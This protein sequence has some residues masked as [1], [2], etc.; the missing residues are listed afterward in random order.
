MISL[1][2]VR[3]IWV[4]LC[5]TAIAPAQVLADGAAL[6]AKNVKEA[7]EGGSSGLLGPIVVT[8]FVPTHEGQGMLVNV[9]DAYGQVISSSNGSMCVVPADPRWTEVVR[10]IA[11]RLGSPVSLSVHRVPLEWSQ[12]DAVTVTVTDSDGG[13]RAELSVPACVY[14]VDELEAAPREV[15]L[16]GT[17]PP[18]GNPKEHLT[19]CA[20]GLPVGEARFRMEC[21]HNCTGGAYDGEDFRAGGQF[22]PCKTKTCE[23]GDCVRGWDHYDDQCRDTAQA[24]CIGPGNCCYTTRC[25]TCTAGFI[26]SDCYGEREDSIA[27]GGSLTQICADGGAAVITTRGC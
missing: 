5:L 3:G 15:E 6:T 8:E 7:P 21:V 14:Y 26:T 4:V 11:R 10:E 18:V 19:M 24:N 17:P 9:K 12:A 25:C 23:P 20:L 16:G 27:N 22:P 2:G 1:L 13:L